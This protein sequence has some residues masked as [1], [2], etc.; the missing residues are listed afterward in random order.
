[1]RR[2]FS[3]GCLLAASALPAPGS[4]EEALQ[5][6]R[7]ALYGQFQPSRIEINDR[8]RRGAV[9]QKGTVV[10]VS[11]AG[12]PAK[13]FRVIE[14]GHQFVIRNRVMDF[15]RVEITPDGQTEVEPGP[16]VLQRGS[17]LVVL[18]VK[19]RRDRVHLL[20][21]TAD[22]LPAPPGGERT[23]G[24]TEFVFRFEPSLLTAGAVEPVLKAITRWLE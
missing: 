9:T 4:A 22:P 14:E 15:A 20:T 13:R 24:C 18:D 11:V 7:N 16:L 21:H 8:L 23:Y 10:T 12:L 2:L 1:M 3:L 19:V 6:L 17:R 5:E